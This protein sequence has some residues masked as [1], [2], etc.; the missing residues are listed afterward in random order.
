M[1][2]LISSRLFHLRNR[3]GRHSRSDILNFD[4]SHRQR[5]NHNNKRNRGRNNR[6]SGGGGGQHGGGGNSIN[7][8]Y[9]SNGPD[10]KVRG[11]AQT[12]AEKYM[13]LGRDAHSSGDNVMAE[14]YYQFAE[15]YFRVLQSMQP[16]G[17][18]APQILRRP[19]EEPEEEVEVVEPDDLAADAA[20][21]EAAEGQLQGSD[22]AGEGASAEGAQSHDGQPQ[23]HEQARGDGQDN[24]DGGRDRFRPRWQQRRD[25]NRDQRDGQG[26][27]PRHGGEGEQQ[28][29]A[30]HTDAVED[31]GGK[32]WEAPSFLTRPVPQVES[33]EPVVAE[34]RPARRSRAKPAAEAPS[35]SETA[36]PS[37][38]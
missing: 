9:E 8:V 17:Q 7:R 32:D 6:R 4:N 30:S 3:T 10:V 25:R 33:S 22:D 13:Q 20:Q 16:P 37:D 21:G 5:Q 11:T 29:N 26:H 1:V 34:A 18:L 12:I 31:A 15:H 27:A 23:R 35:V 28:A 24:R 19:G 38:D 14:S 2:R 36:A